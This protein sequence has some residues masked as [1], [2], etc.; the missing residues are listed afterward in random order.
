MPMG[1][2]RFT[3]IKCRLNGHHLCFSNICQNGDKRFIILFEDFDIIYWL[4]LY[5]HVFRATDMLYN[6]LQSMKLNIRWARSA[7]DCR[8]YTFNDNIAEDYLPPDD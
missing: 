8:A 5:S 3:K 1:T 4:D 6:A 2:Y 7:I